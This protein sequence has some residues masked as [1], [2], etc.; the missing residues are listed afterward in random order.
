VAIGNALASTSPLFAIPLEILF[1]NR[2]PSPR[3][4]AGAA[5]TVVGIACLG[6]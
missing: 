3:T 2:R 4:I 5:L 1:L 6:F